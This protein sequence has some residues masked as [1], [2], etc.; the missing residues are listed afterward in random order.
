VDVP[1]VR[2]FSED[3]AR[4]APLIRINPRAPQ[5]PQRTEGVSLATGA[6]EA[7]Q[8]INDALYAAGF[9]VGG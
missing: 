6:L 1:S 7:M 4:F 2:L 9:W 3:Q 5:R 8:E